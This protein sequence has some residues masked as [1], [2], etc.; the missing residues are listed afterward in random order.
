MSDFDSLFRQT[1]QVLPFSLAIIGGISFMLAS[2][3]DKPRKLFQA[4]G[5][6]TLVLATLSAYGNWLP[7]VE[8][9]FPPPQEV[10]LDVYSMTPQQLA[11]EGEKIIFGGIGKSKEQGA[12]GKGQCPLCHAAQEGI[13]G[14]R[15]PNLRGVID[16]A[17]ERLKDPRYHLGKPN[18]RDTIQH[19]AFPGSGTATNTLEYLAESDVCHSC[20]VVAGYGMR[21]THDTDSGAPS[22]LYAPISLS[23]NDVVA[24]TT[25]LYVND[26]K[27]PPSP[28][29]IENAYRKFV[30]P[31]KWKILVETRN[32]PRFEDRPIAE[33]LATGHE[34]VS[35]MFR[36]AQCTACHT[37]PGIFRATGKI[38]PPLGLKT[39]AAT[40]LKDPSYQGKA[41][42]PREYIIESILDPSAYVVPLFPPLSCRRS[43]A[44]GFLH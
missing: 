24:I 2:Y 17:Q 23:I 31:T 28:G 11:D 13:I 16:R 15:A 36:L 39:K 33:V 44:P 41:T 27:K 4:I 6:M 7:Q 26:G 34:A 43:M 12:I 25:W 10:K 30:D 8:G 18:E 37:I 32:I 20:Y 19:E 35:D 5:L 29:E 14:E 21:G 38:G 9:G 22:S 42:T 1:I 40:R 3:F